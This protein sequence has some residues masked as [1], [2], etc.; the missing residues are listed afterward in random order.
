MVPRWRK[1][2]RLI[3]AV[4]VGL[5]VAP[6]CTGGATTPRSA[7]EPDAVTSTPTTIEQPRPLVGWTGDPLV[8]PFS[9]DYNALV[10]VV[11]APPHEVT[12]DQ[13]LALAHHVLG[14]ASAFATIEPVSGTAT[15]SLPPAQVGPG[16]P[17]VIDRPAWI[18]AYHRTVVPS[19]PALGPSSVPPTA[20]DL[21]AFIITGDQVVVYHGAGTGFCQPIDHPIASSA[22]HL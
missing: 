17:E 12:R 16:V 9:A 10:V 21:D 3:V 13:A 15:L 22:T 14:G 5:L 6:G 8:P 1:H 20:S 11:G 4:A 19:C 2:P 7:G 18:I